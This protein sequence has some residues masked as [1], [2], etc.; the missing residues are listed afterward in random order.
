MLDAARAIENRFNEDETIKNLEP[1]FELAGSITEGTRFGYG[2]EC[3]MGLS[4][5]ALKARKLGKRSNKRQTRH[6]TGRM[7]TTDQ[8]IAFQIDG[9]PYS[10]KKAQTSQTKMDCFFDAS[11]KFEMHKF[12]LCLL[13]ASENA[14]TAMYD[15]GNNPPRLHRIVTNEDWEKG[16]TPCKG[17]CRENL[18]KN[19]YE[20]C[21]K[22]A[23]V[24]SQTKIGMTLQFVWKWPGD[25]KSEAKDIYCSIDIIPEYPIEP[26]PASRLAKL[27]NAAMLMQDPP[28]GW[29]KYLSNYDKHYKI[30]LTQDGYIHYVVLKEMNFLAGRNHHVRP[31][32]PSN[33]SREKFTSERM[34]KIYGYIKFLKKNVDGVDLSSFWVKKELLKDHYEAILD[35][36]K[37]QNGIE[38]NNRALITI[39]SQPEFRS[40]VEESRI[41]LQQTK[42]RETIWFKEDNDSLDSLD[43]DELVNWLNG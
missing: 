39:L 21:K 42:Q 19:N 24:V 4:F 18:E 29:L 8:N 43:I 31:A 16:N 13:E 10:L 30:S 26:I 17:E 9:D 20:Q 35:S 12:K 3:D 34:R 22:C 37:D 38:D 23:V 11:Q 32:Q 5:R 6:R 27:V 40:W 41:D 15:M 33:E 28:M 25:E 7:P 14:V 36:C 1:R 2:N